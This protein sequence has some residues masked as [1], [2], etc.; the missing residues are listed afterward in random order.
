[1]AKQQSNQ[2]KQEQPQQQANQVA[3]QP[4]PLPAGLSKDIEYIPFMA[5]DPIKLSLAIV[6]NFVSAK[7]RSGHVADDTQIVK[8]MLLCK[9]RGLNPFENDAYLVGYDTKD[10]PVFNLITAHQALIKRAEV[11]PE[12]DGM[13][14]GVIVMDSEGKMAMR[15]GSFYLISDALVG[16]WATIFFK[17]RSIPM[18]KTVRLKS[19]D[20][21]YS[22]WQSD[23][24]GMIMKVAEAAALRASF[25]N[26]LG[27]MY[28]RE[29]ERPLEERQQRTRT[30]EVLANLGAK[31]AIAGPQT[32]V[33]HAPR[34]QTE[35]PLTAVPVASQP[36]PIERQTEAPAPVERKP[37]A[38]T[39]EFGNP[40]PAAEEHGDSYEPDA[41]TV[42]SGGNDAAR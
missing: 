23:P 14:S 34:V 22:R 19:Y 35:Q 7:T 8:F 9:A 15:D 11:H 25:P 37:L 33:Q 42:L 21:G 10:G 38:E 30:Q 18:H 39:D 36:A 24:G 17:N 32:V 6:R 4:P 40:L 3:T 16:G 1:M 27:G 12:Y 41:Q 28:I 29:E 2:P 20:T 26:T 5:K 31:P 13:K